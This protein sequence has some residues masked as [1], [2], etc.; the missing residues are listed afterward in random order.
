MVRPLRN[1]LSL[2]Y[3]FLFMCL[4]NASFQFIF[5]SI[6]LD[7]LKFL[8]IVNSTIFTALGFVIFSAVVDYRRW[9]KGY[10]KQCQCVWIPLTTRFRPEKLIYR[11]MILVWP[12]NAYMCTNC[13]DIISISCPITQIIKYQRVIINDLL[14]N[15]L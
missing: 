7:E 3:V 4:I 1:L 11:I 10:C 14:D 5:Q 9:N 12:K 8:I 15:Y 2:F 13:I 6:F